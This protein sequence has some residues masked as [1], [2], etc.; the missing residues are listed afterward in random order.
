MDRLQQGSAEL[1]D[2]VYEYIAFMETYIP[3][4]AH[5]YGFVAGN[6]VFKES[7]I[8]YKPDNKLTCEYKNWLSEYLNIEL[9]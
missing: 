7:V 2:K 3:K 6:T 8:D 5:Y 1:L 9:E 4:L